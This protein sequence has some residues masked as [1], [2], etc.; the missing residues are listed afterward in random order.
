MNKKFRLITSLVIVIA[1]FLCIPINLKAETYDTDKYEIK[2]ISE[3]NMM[4][5]EEF[6]EQAE[7]IT[8]E[9]LPEGLI[10]QEFESE[11]DAYKYFKEYEPEFVL[12]GHIYNYEEDL[13]VMDEELAEDIDIE[14]FEDMLEKLNTDEEYNGLGYSV[15]SV[16]ATSNTKFSKN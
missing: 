14:A 9:E 3:E 4:T 11:E 13:Y 6:W 8:P 16:S 7:D 10:P 12:K 15:Y 2:P 5:F 1:M